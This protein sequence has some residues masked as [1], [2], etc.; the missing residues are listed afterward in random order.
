MYALPRLQLGATIRHQADHIKVYCHAV[1]F[2]NPQVDLIKAIAK[3]AVP[4]AGKAPLMGQVAEDQNHER[5][6][7]WKRGAC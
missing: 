7:L 5:P 3:Q 6:L 2:N 4:L 1:P